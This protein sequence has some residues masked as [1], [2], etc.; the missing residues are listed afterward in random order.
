MDD[1]E[2]QNVSSGKSKLEDIINS[3]ITLVI[4]AESWTSQS[5]TQHG[6]QTGQSNQTANPTTGSG[7]SSYGSPKP[8]TTYQNKDI[9]CQTYSYKYPYQC[10]K[11]HDSYTINN[12]G[13]CQIVIAQCLEYSNSKCTKCSDGYF[14][15]SQG[16]CSA[17]L[18]NCAKHNPTTCKCA[19]CNPGF[20]L[21]YSGN[22]QIQLPPNCAKVNYKGVCILC[23]TNFYLLGQLCVPIIQ[24]C[25]TYDQVTGNCSVC[26]DSYTL[27]DQYCVDKNCLTANKSI[28]IQCAPGYFL[29]SSNQCEPIN[30]SYCIEVN[31]QKEC[32]KC[33]PNYI[34]SNGQ[35][36]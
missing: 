8:P 12:Y 17:N 23:N 4:Q 18:P 34:L 7:S 26:V 25:K 30:I 16:K 9:N 20:Y 31:P 6:Y 5:Y 36:F 19:Q 14:V 32:V 3:R 10:I 24:F 22:C 29:N 28:C 33:L 35:C 1:E 15:T 13:I 27:K 2:F 11:C 21:D